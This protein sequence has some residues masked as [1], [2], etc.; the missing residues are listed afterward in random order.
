MGRRWELSKRA[1][2][3][4]RVILEVVEDKGYVRVK[5]VASVLNVK[6]PSVVEMLQKLNA[7]R[8]IEYRKHDGITLTEEGRKIAE[9]VKERHD[10][11]VALLRL[12]GVAEN[13]IEE[14]AHVMEHE[15]RPET[16]LLIKRF[17]VTQG[18]FRGDARRLIRIR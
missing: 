16:I 12:I 3:Y 14:E 1:E 8:L 18:G 13:V 17:V 2:D 4:L 10:A 11:V 9:V 15:L 5:D 7:L 6:P